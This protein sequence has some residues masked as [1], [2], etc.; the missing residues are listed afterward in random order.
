MMRFKK[1]SPNS[2][3]V[4]SEIAPWTVLL[5]DDE[6]EMHSITRLALRDINYDGHGLRFM[7][8]NSAE[9]ARA[10]MADEPQI[11]LAFIDV[12]METDTA[13][14]DLVTYIRQQRGDKT[15][16][17]ILRTGQPGMAPERNVIRDFD[18]NDYLHKTDATSNK[19]YTSTLSALRSYNDLISLQRTKMQLER[20]RDGLE[21]VIEATANLFKMH[22][23]QQLASG[24]LLQLNAILSSVG[25][26]MIV[27]ASGI[28]L[29][30]TSHGYEV[31]ARSGRFNE[32]P[33]SQL[34]DDV[35]AMLGQSIQAQ[36]SLFINQCLIG[37]FPTRDGVVYMIFL[38][39]VAQPDQVGM[40]L[41]D[42]FSK[43]IPIAFENLHLDR[44]ARETEAEMLAR[45]G[46]VLETR[47][48]EAGNH[49]RRVACL[50]RLLA[51][52]SGLSEEECNLVYQA[53]PMHDVGKVAIPDAILLK[54][55]PLNDLESQYMKRHTELGER[56]LGRSS[57][58]LMRTAAMIA[59]QHHEK[60]DGS[61]YPRGLRGEEI[62]IFGR[63]VAIVDVFD[64]LLHRRCYKE[65]WPLQRVVEL[66]QEQ[67]GKHFDPQL[68]DLLLAQLD[69]AE[70]I[71]ARYPEQTD[72]GSPV[73]IG[74]AS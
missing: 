5:V 28:T 35:Q 24:L 66:M 34:A 20:H 42:L 56:I 38:D 37:Y 39:G 12:V 70:A 72:T 58:P 40:K 50:A 26:S 16:R 19:L 36:K 68:V 18:I 45:L 22:S 27:R 32:R 8:A 64:S 25:N 23:L 49:V 62:H 48:L 17:I 44:E 65:A 63:I 74:Q 3:P 71:L 55:G 57:R 67:R 2:P 11:A 1:E 47:S 53:A 6:P 14:L 54:P 61:G 41:L 51:E 7:V 43:N 69:A 46:D 21:R 29:T 31:L 59:G 9:E 4:E 52:S 10:L 60:F 73:N 13:G 15:M 30:Q 33:D